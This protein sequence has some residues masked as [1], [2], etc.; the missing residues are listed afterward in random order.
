MNT[1]IP[2][3]LQPVLEDY[4]QE[5][6]RQIPSR[7]CAIY[8]L[9]SIALGDFI[10]GQSDVD[11]VAILNSAAAPVD[12]ERIL[13]VHK[14]IDSRYPQWKCEAMYFQKSDLG[15]RGDE[16]QPFPRYLLGKLTWMEHFPLSAVTWWTLK[17]HGITLFGSPAQTLSYSLDLEDL[18]R[19][20]RQN[21]NTYWASWTRRPIRVLKLLSDWAVQWTVLGV[22]RQV[23]TLREHAITSKSGAGEYALRWMP[24]RWR[25]IIQEAL[26]LRTGSGTSFYRSR[27]KRATN[28]FR[29]LSY[30]IRCGNEI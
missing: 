15:C 28:A 22:L 21:L 30:A 19:G 29:F 12:Y 14:L 18:L 11:L 3:I 13:A 2:L 26:A 1:R 4:L 23:Y 20:Q 17:Q 9:G 6:H 8:V 7:C 5:I 24:E 10:P 25:P 16:I 27:L